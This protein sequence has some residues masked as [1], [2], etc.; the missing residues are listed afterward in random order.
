MPRGLKS[1][2]ITAARANELA[3]AHAKRVG[4]ALKTYLAE[5][6]SSYDHWGS[7]AYHIPGPSHLWTPAYLFQLAKACTQ[8]LETSGGFEGLFWQDAAG[9]KF[10]W[11]P[12]RLIGFLDSFEADL[13]DN[14]LGQTKARKSGVWRSQDGTRNR[15]QLRVP[16]R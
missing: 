7:W 1:R 8:S 2:V 13:V 9:Q 5:A 14:A 12:W 15:I 11:H 3:W 6:E 10:R 4:V 16:H